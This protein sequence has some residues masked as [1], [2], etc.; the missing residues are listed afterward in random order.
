[1]RVSFT[2][3]I[4]RLALAAL[5]VSGLPG[6]SNDDEI[7]TQRTAIEKYLTSKNYAYD[8]RGGALC[9]TANRDRADYETAEIASG[10]D[11]V[12]F[13]FAAYIFNSGLG[14]LYYTNIAELAEKNLAGLDTEFW[15]FEPV[16]ARVGNSGLVK[17]VD[18][19]LNGCREGDS[20]QVFLTSELC[21]DKKQTGILPK[22]TPTVFILKIT[23]VT[24][25]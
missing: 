17:G 12:T 13:N 15:S 16:T 21:Y 11:Q 7:D 10:G 5:V 25:Q 20:V 22:N 8:N 3:H 23:D 1:M 6:C 24:K 19:A 9:Y 18:L 14:S 4:L 2:S